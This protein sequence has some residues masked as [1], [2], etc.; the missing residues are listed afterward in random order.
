M[1]LGK[2]QCRLFAVSCVRHLLCNH[3]GAS[4]THAGFGHVGWKYLFKTYPRSIGDAASFTEPPSVFSRTLSGKIEHVKILELKLLTIANWRF[5]SGACYWK[6]T[7]HF[8]W[9]AV[10]AG[11]A[12]LQ[13]CLSERAFDVKAPRPGYPRCL[14]FCHRFQRMTWFWKKHSVLKYF[15]Y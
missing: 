5:L 4:D 1:L 2:L 13:P 14:Y 15:R 11:L 8:I 6:A 10:R 12:A 7:L 9:L 3:L